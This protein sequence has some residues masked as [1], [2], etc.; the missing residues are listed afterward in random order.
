MSDGPQN[1]MKGVGIYAHPSYRV[2]K[3]SIEIGSHLRDWADDLAEQFIVWERAS[4]Q[5][6]S[7]T[8]LIDSFEFDCVPDEIVIL[9]TYHP[10]AYACKEKSLM[11]L[12]GFVRSG[13]Y[14]QYC[15]W[16]EGLPRIV[17]ER[18]VASRLVAVQRSPLFLERAPRFR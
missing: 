5:S 15:C 13:Q 4:T 11:A 6:F 1:R 17:E 2:Q 8:D 14:A 10:R 16:I 7:P 9:R 12:I 3:I 18:G